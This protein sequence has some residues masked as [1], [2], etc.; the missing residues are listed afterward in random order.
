MPIKIEPN[1]L[2][3]N[4]YGSYVAAETNTAMHRKYF[5]MFYIQWHCLAK[6]ELW[7]K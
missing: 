4:V 2:V 3:V 1:D 7:N 5:D 6:L